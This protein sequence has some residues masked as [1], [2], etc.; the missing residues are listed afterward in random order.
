[1][2][3]LP[4][5]LILLIALGGCRTVRET[6]TEYLTVHHA[7]T[8]REVKTQRDSIYVFEKEREYSR[9]DTI[10]V[11]RLLYKYKDRAKTDTVYQVKTVTIT[12]R[13]YYTKEK[14]V[15]RLRWWQTALMWIGAVALLT[16]LVL[17]LWKTSLLKKLF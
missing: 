8:I 16:I 17:A 12:Q 14:E 9:G 3:W 15:N 1:M 5:L 4:F 13:L 2:R 7:D 6:Q 11:E 10:F